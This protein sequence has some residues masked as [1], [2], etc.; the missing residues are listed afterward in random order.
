MPSRTTV[1]FM[2]LAVTQTG[3]STTEGTR[4]CAVVSSVVP[5]R[6]ERGGVVP[7]RR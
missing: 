4:T 5:L 7:A 2:L 3:G 1:D 6:S